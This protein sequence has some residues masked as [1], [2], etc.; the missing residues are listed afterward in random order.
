MS[1]GF[2][3][4]SSEAETRMHAATSGRLVTTQTGDREWLYLPRSQQS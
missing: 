3:I 2:D 1:D 4:E